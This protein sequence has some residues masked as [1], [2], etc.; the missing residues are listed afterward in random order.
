MHAQLQ[1]DG[2]QCGRRRVARLMRGLGLTGRHRRR[3]SAARSSARRTGS[4]GSRSSSRPACGTPGFTTRG[5][6]RRPC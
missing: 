5:A 4:S 6:P 1:R 2:Q 3:R